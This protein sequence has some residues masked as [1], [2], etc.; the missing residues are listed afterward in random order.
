LLGILLEEPLFESDARYF[1]VARHD[2]V[3]LKFILEAYEGLA[4]LSTVEREGA[5]VRIGYPH[6]SAEDVDRLLHA[7]SGEIDLQEVPQ[8]AGLCDGLPPIPIRKVA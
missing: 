2:L 1:R 7:L 4:V 5:I 6:F 8:P 3:Y